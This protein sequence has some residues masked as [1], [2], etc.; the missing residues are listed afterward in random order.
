MRLAVISDVHGNTLALRSVLERIAAEPVD[1]IVCLGDLAVNGF[2]PSGAIQRIAELGC[3]VIRGNTD[4]FL[5][6][7][8]PEGFFAQ[9]DTGIR[10]D[11][12]E[13]TMAQISPK[14]RAFLETLVPVAELDLD[15]VAICCYHGSPLSYNDPVLPGTPVEDLEH[16]FAGTDAPLLIGGHTHR[17]MLRRWNGRTIVNPGP[18]SLT[19]EPI[20]VERGNTRPWTEYAIITSDSG[21]ISVDFRYLPLDL[22]ALATAARQSGMPHADWW[23]K[24][25]GIGAG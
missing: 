20:P 10:R 2:D 21:S 23:L 13:W 16:Y 7:G 22:D 15:G 4:D 11:L 24:S 3:P 14:H 9:G 5:V 12:A 1:R 8:F 6:G 25:W 19:F 18:V 17:Q